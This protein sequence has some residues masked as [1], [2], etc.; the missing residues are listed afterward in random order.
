MG[1]ERKISLFHCS[2]SGQ[3]MDVEKA[4]IWNLKL[5]SDRGN[6]V[7]VPRHKLVHW[8]IGGELI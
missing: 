8:Y 5:A 1:E 6:T 2:L 3:F 4:K 7:A